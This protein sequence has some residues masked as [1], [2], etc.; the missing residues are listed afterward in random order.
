MGPR[1]IIFEQ[2]WQRLL[3]CQQRANIEVL[4]LSSSSTYLSCYSTRRDG[5][6]GLRSSLITCFCLRVFI[7]EETSVNSW[8]VA[9]SPGCHP[10]SLEGDNSSS[11]AWSSTL[12]VRMRCPKNALTPSNTGSP[13][14][15]WTDR[16]PDW[17]EK[18]NI[19]TSSNSVMSSG[20]RFLESEDF[21]AGRS[22]ER[23]EQDAI[24]DSY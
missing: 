17:Q 19:A 3:Q 16:S 1:L 20:R 11:L 23:S 24:M 14:I 15:L 8:L 9:S 13:R 5:T 21:A 6:V 18:V 12:A 10:P 4:T 2:Y 7:L 22:L